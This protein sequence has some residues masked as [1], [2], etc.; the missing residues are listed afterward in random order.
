MSMAEFLY[1]TADALGQVM[2]EL[3]CALGLDAKIM[4]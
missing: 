4:P 1:C 3:S 2:V